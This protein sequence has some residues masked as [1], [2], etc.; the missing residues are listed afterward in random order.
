MASRGGGSPPASPSGRAGSPDRGPQPHAAAGAEAATQEWSISDVQWD[1]RIL[2]AIPRAQSAPGPAQHPAGPSGRSG[3]PARH[4]EAAVS[5]GAAGIPGGEGVNLPVVMGTLQ[6]AAG[7]KRKVPLLCQVCS[8]ASTSHHAILRAL[9]GE[10]GEEG[11]CWSRRRIKWT[12]CCLASLLMQCRDC[13]AVQKTSSSQD[14]SDGVLATGG[15]LQ[16]GSCKGKGVLS[17]LSHL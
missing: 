13:A 8:A 12:L 14:A 4:M 1:P 6:S 9:F 15:W 3:S 10:E 11:Q 7:A 2:T 5:E 16:Q 17:T